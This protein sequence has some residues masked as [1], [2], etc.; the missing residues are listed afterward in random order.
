[1]HDLFA[2]FHLDNPFVLQTLFA[3][4]SLA[5]GMAGMVIGQRSAT[6]GKLCLLLGCGVGVGTMWLLATSY[7]L[8]APGFAGVFVF[9]FLASSGLLKLAQVGATGP[10]KKPAS[11]TPPAGGPTK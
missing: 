10:A 3:F 8:L 2:S 6:Q 11:P 1:M 4:A 9:S 5:A 7:A